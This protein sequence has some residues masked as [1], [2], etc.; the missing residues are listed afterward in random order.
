M[1]LE[2]SITTQDILLQ[3]AL[4]VMNVNF[5]FNEI[6][7]VVVYSFNYSTVSHFRTIP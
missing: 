1:Y 3:L 7:V 4:N 5:F 6:H 2:L